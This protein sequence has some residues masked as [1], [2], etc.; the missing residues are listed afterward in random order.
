MK[1]KF[2]IAIPVYNRPEYLR[3]A[4]RSCLAQTVPDFEIVVSDDCSPDD[5]GSV[6]SSFG[7]SRISYHRS[8]ERLGAAR[9]HQLSVSLSQGEYVVNLH[10]D[11][12]LLPT[13]LESAHYKQQ[14]WLLGIRC[15]GSTAFTLR[16]QR[17]R[18][19]APGHVSQASA[20][21]TEIPIRLLIGE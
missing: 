15:A 1:H 13:Y 5:L 14:T 19:D 9:N 6:V 8:M 17:M 20:I 16:P 12:L 10:S 11:D 4:I 2:T 18:P 3:Q 21:F 7:D